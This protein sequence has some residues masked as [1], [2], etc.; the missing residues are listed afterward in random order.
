[1]FKR[2][3]HILLIWGAC[4][5]SLFSLRAQTENVKERSVA[6][7]VLPVISAYTALGSVWY[8]GFETTSFHFFNDAGEWAGVDKLGHAFSAQITAEAVSAFHPQLSTLQ[9]SLLGFAYV[10]GIEVLD[11]FAKDWG[12]SVSDLAA[13]AF[14]SSLFF[15]RTEKE[16]PLYLKWSYFPSPSSA[17]KN[18]RLLGGN[19]VEQIL[20]NYN[21]QQYWLSYPLLK[22]K[23]GSWAIA[24]GRGA[25][26]FISARDGSGY[27]SLSIDF[28]PN[29]QAPWFVQWLKYIKLPLPAAHFDARGVGFSFLGSPD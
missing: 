6:W 13:N 22:S 21:A 10:S 28:L 27:F 7:S 12:A 9:A 1:M 16:L 14:G 17:A 23:W 15:L 11:G 5:G 29:S 20:K 4:K 26:D 18:E 25:Q 8:K 19:G 3:V 2:I 24:L